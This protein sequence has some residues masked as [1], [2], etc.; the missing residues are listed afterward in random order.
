MQ[1]GVS[2]THMIYA[3]HCKV[4]GHELHDG[5]HTSLGGRAVMYRQVLQGLVSASFPDSTPQLFTFIAL[6]I[7]AGRAVIKSWGVESG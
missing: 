7:K 1:L 2:Y 3:L 5:A 6:C 4:E